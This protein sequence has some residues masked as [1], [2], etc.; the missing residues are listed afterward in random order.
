MREIEELKKQAKKDLAELKEDIEV[1]KKNISE[2][3]KIV[4]SAK[5]IG[6]LDPY[7]DWEVEEGLKHISLF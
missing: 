5:S 4:D 7:L 2:I 3:E 1:L 6:D